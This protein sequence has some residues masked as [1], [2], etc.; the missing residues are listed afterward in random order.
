MTNAFE[1]TVKSSLE[2]LY[3]P[4]NNQ[5]LENYHY[6]VD[7]TSI[8]HRRLSPL[9]IEPLSKKLSRRCSPVVLTTAMFLFAAIAFFITVT[10]RGRYP[11]YTFPTIAFFTVL[12][13]LTSLLIRPLAKRR[14]DRSLLNE[15]LQHTFQVLILGIF[16]LVGALLFTSNEFTY[17]A[18]L[19][20]TTHLAYFMTLQSFSK[21]KVALHLYPISA[22]EALGMLVL[23]CVLAIPRELYWDLMAPTQLG[24][25]LFDTTL[26]AV[27]F[28]ALATAVDQ[29]RRATLYRS[30]ATLLYVA[31]S[32]FFILLFLT[33]ERSL[34]PLVLF[35][36]FSSEYMGRMILA[37]MISEKEPLPD[38]IPV[39]LVLLILQ[40]EQ[41]FTNTTIS[42]DL[43]AIYFVARLLL[44][45][46]YA[47]LTL[48]DKHEAR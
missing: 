17:G 23:L 44:L 1:K 16:S 14:G 19:I 28:V 42:A 41:H 36:L 30:P 32:L 4:I 15:F 5:V 31:S 2:R 13:L 35:V 8:L 18:T 40:V 24:I 26:L 10:Y 39:V 45:V 7:N 34:H 12:T 38:F 29:L 48:S 43:L 6:L 11:L 25:S 47:F 22:P 37:R 3:F 33:L 9:L 46:V 27:S 21:R 20:V